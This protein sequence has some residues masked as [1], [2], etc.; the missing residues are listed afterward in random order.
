M[1]QSARNLRQGNAALRLALGLPDAER[2]AKEISFRMASVTF[3]SR[4]TVVFGLSEHAQR[5]AKA[6]L[7]SMRCQG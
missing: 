3:D 6:M 5:S 4:K 2:M 7:T 1:W